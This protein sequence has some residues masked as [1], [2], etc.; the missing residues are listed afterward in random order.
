MA[1]AESFVDL[2]IADVPDL[3]VVEED[4][5]QVTCVGTE[6]KSGDKG[7]Y[8]LLRLKIEGATDVKRVTHVMMFPGPDSDVDQTNNRLRS[9]RVACQAFGVPFTKKGFNL[10]DFVGQS[11]WARLTVEND[12]DYGESNRVRRFILTEEDEE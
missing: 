12:P 3:G 7:P 1:T 4:D 10:E 5:W 2:N 8:A 11:A 9:L 6:M